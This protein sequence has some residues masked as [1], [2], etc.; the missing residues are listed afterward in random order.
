MKLELFPFAK[1]Q[2]LLLLRKHPRVAPIQQINSVEYLDSSLLGG[3]SKEEYRLMK[4]IIATAA[5][6][7]FLLALA[8]PLAFSQDASAK[9]AAQDAAAQ[10][11][12]VYKTWYDLNNAKDYPKALE[13]A[14][15]YLEK[16]PNGQYAAYLKK[17]MPTARAAM[18]G[19]A[20][21]AK[22]L[23]EIDRLGKEIMA[24]DP[25]NLDFA[26]FLAS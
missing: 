11:A 9:P 2:Q 16:Y 10:E 19:E 15:A 6:L 22:N 3:N 7:T 26:L 23:A 18:L 17:W 21:K 8:A 14:Q 20:V 1:G 5:V 25:E 12:A 24:A 13:A 4:K